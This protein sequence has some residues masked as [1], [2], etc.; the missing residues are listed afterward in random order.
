MN[1]KQLAGIA[2]RV[3]E[4]IGRAL[5]TLTLRAVTAAERG[6]SMVEYSIVLALVA[7]VAM[8]AIQA[9]GVGVGQVFTNILTRITT[10][11][12]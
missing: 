4:R 3:A 9:L 12:R 10:L 7:I 8:I 2:G 5:D 1:L 6:Q 11:G